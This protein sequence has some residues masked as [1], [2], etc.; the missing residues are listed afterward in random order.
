MSTSYPSEGGSERPVQAVAVNPYAYP[1]ARPKKSALGKIFLAM[2][3]IA[4]FG[5]ILMN[6]LLV[7]AVGVRGG[8]GDA[9][10]QEKYVSHDRWA[11]NKIAILSIEGVIYNGEGFF[12]RQLDHAYQ[13][14]EAGNLKALVIRVNSPGGTISGSDYMLHH[15]QEFKKKTKVPIVVS[16]GA[17]AASG[18]YYVSMA[19]GDKPDTIFAE[20]TTWTGSIGVII[21]HYNLTGLMKQVGIEQDEI[22]SHRLKGMGTMARPMTE[23]EKQIFQGLVDDGFKRFKEVVQSGRPKFKE[24]PAA[25]D[26]LATGQI[27]TA[28]QALENGLVD[29]LGFIDDAV[30]RAIKLAGLGSDDNVSVVQYKDEPTLADALLGGKTQVQPSIDWAALLDSTSPRGYYLCTWLPILA[31]KTE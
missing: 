6:L 30:D 27:F 8:G 2:L 11:S 28:D 21:P 5:S 9:R 23:E 20:P 16:M 7:V 19:V 26:K 25:L 17:M 14:A 24:D 10:I 18:G 12:K 13:E 1:P 4:F 15:L 22:T 31:G 3:L 29:K